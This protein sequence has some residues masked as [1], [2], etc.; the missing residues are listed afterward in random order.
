M[1][2]TDRRS[3]VTDALES[4][5][6]IIDDNAGRDAIHIAVEPVIAAERLLPGQHVGFVHGGSVG[7]FAAKKI[8]I[9]D[10]FLPGF[11]EKGERF[12]LMI[13]PRTI[14]S[15]RHVWAH[16]DFADAATPEAHAPVSDKDYSSRWMTDWAVKHMGYDYYGDGQ[17]STETALGNAID[18]GHRLSVGPYENARDSIDEEW[19]RHWETITGEKGRRGEYFSCAC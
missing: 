5:G 10:P 14:T 16:P 4:L 8:G 7:A 11:L 9:V 18:A 3:T 19:W 1:T 12:W 6:T 2:N 17:I 13:Y 15:L